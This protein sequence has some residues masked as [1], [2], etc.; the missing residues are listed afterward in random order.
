MGPDTAMADAREIFFVTGEVSGDRHAAP[1]VGKLRA[2]GMSVSGVGG[3]G[4]RAAGAKLI[5]D[6]THWGVMGVP[7]ALRRLPALLIRERWLQAALRRLRP[8]IVVL[9]DF[10]AFNVRLARY[11]RKTRLSRV[12]YYFPPGSWRQEPRDWSSLAALTDCIA[13]PF[14]KNAEHLA[15]SGANAHW[16]G[17]PIVDT[18]A[19][20]AD[21]AALRA[22]L[23][24]RQKPPVVGVL[25]GSRQAE[26]R[27]IGPLMVRAMRTILDTMPECGFLW[28]CLPHTNHT[29][30][31]LLAR[32]SQDVRIARVDDSRD[33]IRASDLLLATMGT[34]TLEAAAALTPMVTTYDASFVAKWIAARLLKQQQ[35]FYSMPNLMLGRPAVPEVV[36]LGPA[37]RI[38]AQRIARPALALLRDGAARKAMQADLGLVRDLLGRPGVAARTADLIMQALDEE[39]RN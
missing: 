35:A 24:L 8:P 25:P 6:S 5:A 31:R 34:A 9:V 19:P 27:T 15:A 20:V 14:A 30:D 32:L 21:R 17:H 26:R 36:P 22:E 38:T 16:V 4:M 18:L 10:G 3:E 13:T 1:V 33:I 39:P 2:R 7:Q 29:D 23:G 11:L 37:D 28:S 12:F